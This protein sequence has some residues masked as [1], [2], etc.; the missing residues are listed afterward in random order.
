MQKG[1]NENNV[2]EIDLLRLIKALLDKLWAIVLCAIIAGGAAFGLTYIFI[3][4]TYQASTQLYVN[5][6]G[7][8][9][10][11]TSF[12]ISTSSLSA[13]QELVNT[14][15]VI[16]KTRSTLSEIIEE[17]KVEG[18]TVNQLKNMITASPVNSTEIFEIV[19]ESNNPKLSETLA[20]SIAKVLPKRIAEIVDGSSVRIVDYAIAP[21]VRSGP[22]YSKFTILGMV[23]GAL[24]CI[25][26]IV[27]R[28]IF[29]SYIR[30][31]SY[32]TSAY[33]V[34]VLAAIPDVNDSK[35]KSGYYYSS[36]SANEK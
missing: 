13:A 22:S 16:L 19:V 2:L 34:P 25:V 23:I 28:E 36:Y 10:G 17:S 4:P 20:N 11:N 7:V 30:E 1:M 12:N 21:K 24:L 15:I 29:D 33:S 9:V 35:S 14:Y 3:E 32:L 8:S 31:E 6:N 5:N 26:I 27:V 18:I